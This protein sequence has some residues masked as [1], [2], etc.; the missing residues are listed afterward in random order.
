MAVARRNAEPRS[1]T[2]FLAVSDCRKQ[3]GLEFETRL[4]LS[5]PKN[6]RQMA[7]WM[8]KSHH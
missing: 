6:W 1:V 5:P 7:E 8:R 4:M 2:I 3:R